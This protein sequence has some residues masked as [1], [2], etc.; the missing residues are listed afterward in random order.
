MPGVLA[1]LT[2]ADYAADG[3]GSIP[4]DMSQTRRDGSPMF[5][6]VNRPLV[7]DRVRMVG[8]YVALVVAETI[9]QAKDAAEL[10]EVVQ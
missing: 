8:D 9:E 10:V 2:G 4:C 6:P 1:V 5:E 7:L 3:L